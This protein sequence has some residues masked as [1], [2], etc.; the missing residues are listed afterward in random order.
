MYFTASVTVSANPQ[1]FLLVTI[2]V[3][4]GLL[5]FKAAMGAR[6]YKSFMIDIFETVLYFNIVALAAFSLHDFKVDITKQTAIA[7]TSTV[8]TFILLVAA[9]VY[10]VMLFIRR[11]KVLQKVNEYPLTP[12]QQ[13]KVEVISDYHQ[14]MNKILPV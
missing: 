3:I 14:K 11:D 6:V 2:I 10:H 9:V 12:V 7:Y 8:I 1:T 4:V 5:I 13:S